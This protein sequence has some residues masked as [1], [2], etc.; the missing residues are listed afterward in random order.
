MLDEPSA[1]NTSEENHLV[2]AVICHVV[3]PGREEGYRRR[4]QESGAR[5]QN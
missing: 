3:R 5:I 4:I 1:I 2:T